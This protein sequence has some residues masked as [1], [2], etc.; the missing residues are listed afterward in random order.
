MGWNIEALML[1]IDKEPETRD[2]CQS[3]HEQRVS[4]PT[5]RFC[6]RCLKELEEIANAPKD[7]RYLD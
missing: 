7:A 1:G 4:E 5:S 2:V 6:V 3:C